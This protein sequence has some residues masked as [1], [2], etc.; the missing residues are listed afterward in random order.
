MYARSECQ[1]GTRTAMPNELTRSTLAAL[2]IAATVTVAVSWL[3]AAGSARAQQAGYIRVVTAS[4]HQV[5]GES[6]DP[7]HYGWIPFRQATM[8]TR[9][10]IEAIARESAAGSTINEAKAVHRPVVIVKDRDRSSL[11][12]LAAM[13]SHQRL[14][15]VDV[16]LTQNDD[17]VARYK[18]TDATIISV[19]AGSTDGNTDAPQEQL[20]FNYAKIEIE[21]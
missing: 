10:E 13:T 5:A 12:L 15:E 19:S 7:A 11:V 3:W 20:R 21:R 9:A 6:T 4:G 1:S 17:P 2:R 14:P 16:V 18:L 8:P